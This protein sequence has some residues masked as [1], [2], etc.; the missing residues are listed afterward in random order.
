M[1][2]SKGTTHSHSTKK[3]KAKARSNMNTVRLATCMY[4]STASPKP[5]P[6]NYGPPYGFVYCTQPFFFVG[7]G[8][9]ALKR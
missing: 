8:H 1:K 4:S 9:H 7:D 2:E 3:A 6:D 5:K